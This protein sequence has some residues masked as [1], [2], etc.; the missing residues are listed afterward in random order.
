MNRAPKR[1]LVMFQVLSMLPMERMYFGHGEGEVILQPALSA[2]KLRL[3]TSS[4]EKPP[5][6]RDGVSDFWWRELRRL[7]FS[8]LTVPFVKLR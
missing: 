5:I 4:G 1:A 6:H 8:E 2:A 7:G 3:K